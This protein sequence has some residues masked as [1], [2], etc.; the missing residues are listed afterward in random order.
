MKAA[1]QIIIAVLFVM[2]LAGFAW[3]LAVWLGH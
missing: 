3:W 1:L 2:A